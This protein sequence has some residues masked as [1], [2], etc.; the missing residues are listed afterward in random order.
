MYREKAWEPPQGVET[1][2]FLFVVFLNLPTFQPR[3]Y[4]T[5]VIVKNVIFIIWLS[6]LPCSSIRSETT[7]SP[8]GVTVPSL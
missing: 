3:V 8:E 4:F 5:H 6:L 2:P 1:V 7:E